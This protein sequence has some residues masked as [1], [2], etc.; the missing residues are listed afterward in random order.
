MSDTDPRRRT[1]DLLAALGLPDRD[2]EASA[3]SALRFPDGAHYRVEIPSVE[4]PRCVEAVL[5]EAARL[6]VPVTRISQGTGVGLL[7]DGEIADM[8]SMT[9]AAGVELSLFARPSAGWDASAMSRAPA[10]AVVAY[11]GSGVTACH[12]LLALALAG[13]EDALLYEGS[14]SDWAKDRSLPAALGPA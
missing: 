6:G 1:A 2:R 4:G 14:W 3:T 11:C 10:G 12:D 8:V 13:R 9:A 7:T 5:G